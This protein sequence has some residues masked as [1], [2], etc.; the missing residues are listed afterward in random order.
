M[1]NPTSWTPHPSPCSCSTAAVGAC[2]DWA[3]SGTH[4]AISTFWMCPVLVSGRV[5]NKHQSRVLAR[6]V[7][8]CTGSR[9]RC[10][11]WSA[12]RPSMRWCGTRTRT[13]T[14]RTASGRPPRCALASQLILPPGACT[15]TPVMGAANA[16]WHP[17]QA[18]CMCDRRPDLSSAC[19]APRCAP[20]DSRVSSAHAA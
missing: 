17:C 18:A 15:L 3:V 8:C 10:G 1:P 11:R 5:P 14:W 19:T 6:G 9:T 2:C 4:R 13:A 12:T 16:L 20:P 7:A